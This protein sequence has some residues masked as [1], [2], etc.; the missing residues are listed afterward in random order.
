[1]RK[2][3]LDKDFYPMIKALEACEEK[4]NAV[5]PEKRAEIALVAERNGGYNYVYRYT[6]F[7][8]GV[9]DELNYR[10][11]ERLIKTVLWVGGG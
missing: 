7:Q 5:S 1:M 2:P 11:A 3:V 4:V 8:D 9:D 10:V 6:A